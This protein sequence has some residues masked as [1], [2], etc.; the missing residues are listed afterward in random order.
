MSGVG[1]FHYAPVGFA[2]SCW[3][4]V[5]LAAE[6]FGFEEDESLFAEEWE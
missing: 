5:Y 4:V 6:A 1:L 2:M 3:A